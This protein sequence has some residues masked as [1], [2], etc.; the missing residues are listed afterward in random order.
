MSEQSQADLSFWQRLR[1]AFRVSVPDDTD[2]KAVNRE[3][4]MLVGP[5]VAELL[6]TQVCS[7]V[8]QM[9]VGNLGIWATA[10]IGYCSQPRLIMLAAFQALNTGATALVARFK[11]A[12]DPKNANRVLHQSIQL[13]LLLS[14]TLAIFGYIFARSVVIFMGAETEQTIENAVIYLRLMLVSLPF[15]TLALAI[16]A[17]LRGIGKTKVSMVYNIVANVVNVA[18]SSVLIYGNLGFPRLEVAGA[19]IAMGM[20]QV[21]ACIIAIIAIGKRSDFFRFRISGIFRFDYNIMK[22]I[23]KIGAPAM[24][25]QLM[26]RGGVLIYTKVIASL[27]TEVYATHNIVL[28]IQSLSAMNGQAFGVAATALVGQNLGRKRPDLAKVSI[29]RCRQFGMWIAT[30][31]A[32][33]FVFFGKQLCGMYTNDQF[34]ID[35]GASVLVII[36]ILQPFFSSQQIVAGALR[37]AG[38][39]RAVAFCTLLCTMILRPILAVILVRYTSLG[40]MG[41]WLAFFADQVARSIYTIIRFANGKWE[42]IE[43]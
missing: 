23:L 29:Y 34:V 21:V 42:K 36:A 28:N 6:L 22:R 18:L 39:T 20:G 5:V 24:L 19:G 2:S 11:G 33:S 25:E 14:L 32:L 15:T 4:G 27:G 8:N 40:L 3:I 31:L 16:T 1:G 30:I 43:V 13:T 38:D 26:Q 7:M 35:L 9:M 17:I 12:N 10:S 41:A 37:G